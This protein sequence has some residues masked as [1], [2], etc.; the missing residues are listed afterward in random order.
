[1]CF[2]MIESE[3]ADTG[4]F[5]LVE[6]EII[7]KLDI[8]VSGEEGRGDLAYLQLFCSIL[9]EKC[10]AS[11]IPRVK[12]GGPKFIVAVEHLLRRLLDLRM[13]P[14]GDEVFMHI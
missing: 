3:I 10:A 12:E 2:D 14:L 11:S 1:M 4:D 13:V 6:T 5:K 8:L 9:G 7:D